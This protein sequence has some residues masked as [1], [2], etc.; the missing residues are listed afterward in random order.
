MT[1]SISVELV[2]HVWAYIVWG[3]KCKA[4]SVGLLFTDC[5]YLHSPVHFHGVVLN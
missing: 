4:Y 2:I 1:V 3:R 5:P